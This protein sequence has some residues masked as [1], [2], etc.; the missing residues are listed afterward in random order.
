LSFLSK[1]TARISKDKPFLNKPKSA[2]KPLGYR[3]G[4]I[5]PMGQTSSEF[6][7]IN[8]RLEKSVYDNF[9]K[10]KYGMIKLKE[11]K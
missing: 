7:K 3:S 2:D 6:A 10:F 5:D 1:F 4:N 11:F 8:P 9:E